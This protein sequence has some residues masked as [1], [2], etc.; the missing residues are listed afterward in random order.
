MVYFSEYMIISPC[1]RDDNQYIMAQTF[2]TH[3]R[4]QR[5]EEMRRIGMLQ[6]SGEI[7]QPETGQG[8]ESFHKAGMHQVGA[9]L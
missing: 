7:D 3:G 9:S 1:L 8:I 5:S 2:R 6:G 4:K